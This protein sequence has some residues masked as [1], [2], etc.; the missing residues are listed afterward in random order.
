[1]PV[2]RPDVPP[3]LAALIMKCLAKRPDDRWQSADELVRRLEHLDAPAVS[4]A[5]IEADRPRRTVRARRVAYALGVAAIAAAAWTLWPR[6]HSSP[7]VSSPTPPALAVLVFQ[8]GPQDD[9]E[10]LAVALTVS[11]IGALGDVPRLNVRS[12]RAVWPIAT[13]GFR[14]TPSRGVL[15]YPGWSEVASTGLGRRTSSGGT[16][17]CRNWP[18]ARR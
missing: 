15:T 11:L 9:L 16:D 12:L 18:S 3:A 1:L 4:S 17:R 6:P 14:S 13:R 2:H 10:P 5:T 8:H 7:T